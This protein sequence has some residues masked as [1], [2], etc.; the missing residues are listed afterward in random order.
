MICFSDAADTQRDGFPVHARCGALVDLQQPVI[1]D[2]AGA[3]TDSERGDPI[4]AEWIAAWYAPDGVRFAP[5]SWWGKA[6][7]RAHLIR[8]GCLDSTDRGASAPWQ[9]IGTY[10]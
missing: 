4:N 6:G 5:G 7:L 1:A 8:L 2:L 9:P 3:L 10:R